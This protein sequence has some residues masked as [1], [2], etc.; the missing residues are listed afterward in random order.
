MSITLIFLLLFA[1]LVYWLLTQILPER[2]KLSLLRPGLGDG[3]LDNLN[4]QRHQQGL[5]LLELDPDLTIVAE[6]KAVH[7][8]MTGLSD[9]GW[10]YPDEYSDMFGQSLLM[11]MLF[12]G[13]METM[14]DRMYRQRDLDDG[15]WVRCGIGVAG[16]QSGQVVVA[17][18]L[19][20]EAWEPLAEVNRRL[21]ADR[22]PASD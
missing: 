16:S 21:L 12:T 19:C 6:D 9:E 18:I 10:T 4:E 2:R 14:L 15:E 8:L 5:P 20:R 7:Q 3:L 17:L 22:L 13:P 1:L 11:E